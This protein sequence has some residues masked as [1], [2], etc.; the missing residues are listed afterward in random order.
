MAKPTPSFSLCNVFGN[1]SLILFQT[2][3]QKIR[4]IRVMQQSLLERRP[5]HGKASGEH[6]MQTFK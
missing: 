3:D 1:I 5:E 2:I 6:L 4:N